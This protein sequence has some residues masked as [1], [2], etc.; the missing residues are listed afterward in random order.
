MWIIAIFEALALQ[1]PP[2]EWRNISYGK[3][4]NLIFKLKEEK[5][6][7]A[8]IICLTQCAFVQLQ[9]ET[10]GES[11]KNQFQQELQISFVFC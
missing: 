1:Q 4:G 7:L 2:H 8:K 5:K 10:K 6:E 11:L 3:K 9:E